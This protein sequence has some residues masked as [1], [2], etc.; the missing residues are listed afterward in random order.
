MLP[1]DIWA[2]G[3]LPKQTR[4]SCPPRFSAAPLHESALPFSTGH[5]EAGLWLSVRKLAGRRPG[6]PRSRCGE[7]A[8]M[9]ACREA[10]RWRLS[11]H[12][13]IQIWSGRLMET[14]W[15]P[16]RRRW[17]RSHSGPNRGVAWPQVGIHNK[18]GFPRR[19]GKRALALALPSP[20]LQFCRAGRAPAGQQ[21][22]AAVASAWTP[23]PKGLT[24]GGPSCSLRGLIAFN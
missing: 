13:A 15:P 20:R 24:E 8:V 5:S 9:P 21:L 6:K 10:L 18:P 1:G 11:Q 12:K 7:S 16:R 3:M 23:A 2:D 14:P 19:L 22:P 17:T 4:M